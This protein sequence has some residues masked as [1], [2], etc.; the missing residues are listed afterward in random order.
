MSKI[1]LENME[2]HAFH[3]CM[4]HEKKLGNTFL[5]TL[6]MKL[7]TKKAGLSDKLEDTLNYQLVYDVVKAQMAIPSNLIEHVG[8]RIM[9][10]VMSE[11]NQIEM[12]KL[13]LSKLAPPL[14]GKVE[15]VSIKLEKKR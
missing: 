4:E 2:F 13:K 5:V 8:Q 9:D 6:N 14:G 1:I 15:A 3:G 10:A 7:D 12:I 11:F